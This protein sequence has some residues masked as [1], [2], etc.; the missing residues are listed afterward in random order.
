MLGQF[1]QDLRA[2]EISDVPRAYRYSCS[3]LGRELRRSVDW[4]ADCAVTCI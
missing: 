2:G 3:R 1:T 4:W